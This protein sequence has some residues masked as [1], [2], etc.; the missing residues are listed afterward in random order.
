MI[1]GAGVTA[2]HDTKYRSLKPFE[3]AQEALKFLSTQDIL[4]GVISAG[5]TVKQ[6]EKVIRLKIGQYFDSRMI[7]FTDQL[8][9][10]K[11]N[12]RLYRRICDELNLN[13]RQC[14]YVGDNPIPDIDPPNSVGMI[15][16]LNRRSGKY[17]DVQG[18]TE[19]THIVHNFW[20]LL[21]ILKNTYGIG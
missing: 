17:K 14:M 11:E 19:P 6:A 4:M 13:P 12:P 7:F 9:M 18:K 5:I 2:Y 15:T 20:D 16:V 1:V 3:D 21:D 10:A 8:G